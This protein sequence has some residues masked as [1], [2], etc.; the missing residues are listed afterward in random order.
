MWCEMD[1]VHPQN[2]TR[3]HRGLGS[4]ILET[5]S[6]GLTS[7]LWPTQAD[8]DSFGRFGLRCLARLL[9]AELRVS[10]FP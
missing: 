10:Q 8:S 7:G 2:P 4:V 9:Q 5:G 3:M 1:F 6:L